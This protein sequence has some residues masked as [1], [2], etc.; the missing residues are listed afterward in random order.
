MLVHFELA[1][2]N[3]G[4]GRLTGYEYKKDDFRKNFPYVLSGKAYI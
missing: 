4:E 3:N 1:F 2:A